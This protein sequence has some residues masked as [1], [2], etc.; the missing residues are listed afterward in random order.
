MKL[1]ENPTCVSSSDICRRTDMTVLCAYISSVQFS[2]V[3]F[4]FIKALS[5]QPTVQI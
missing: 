2:L 1:H 4:P 5:E 3:Q